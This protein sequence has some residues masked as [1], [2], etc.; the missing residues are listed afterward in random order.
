[1]TRRKVVI[2]GLG[3]VSP[4]GV[5]VETTWEGLVSG[6]SGIRRIAGFDPAEFTTQIAGECVDFTADYFPKVES[7]KIDRFSQFALVCADEALKDSGLLDSDYDPQRVGV[8]TGSGIGGINELEAQDHVL[9]ERGPS[10]ITPFFIPKMM[11]NAMSGVISIKYGFQGTSFVTGSACASASHAMGMALRAIQYGEADI[12]LSGGSEAAIT[13][14]AIGGFCAL[15]AL[16]RRNDDPE[17]ASRPFDK[18][19]DGFVMGEGCAILVLEEKERALARGA[20]IYAEFA[21]FGST[22]DAFHIT[23]P[24]EDGTGPARAMEQALS[25]GSLSPDQIDYVNAHG[26]STAYNDVVETRA[27]K[28]VFGSHA[29]Q[30]AISSS[31]SMVG[32]LLGAAGAIGGLVSILSVARGVVHPTRNLDEADPECDLD[33]VPHEAREIPVRGAICNAL[34]FGGHN[35]CLAF[36]SARA[37]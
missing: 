25:D 20:R 15:K 16:S 3:C 9:I 17:A 35:V 24:K 5:G 7:K 32:H 4:L 14:L 26:T 23:A 33:Y 21:G 18:D 12:I 8:I 11:A 1:M 6:R 31:K 13:P 29:K 19:R 28:L 36:R 22:A 30:L 37:S 10:R 34:G 2:T 27:I